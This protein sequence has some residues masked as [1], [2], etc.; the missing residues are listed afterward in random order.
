MIK[1]INRKKEKVAKKA[2]KGNRDI[3]TLLRRVQKRQK[4]S[5]IKI[6]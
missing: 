2:P 5:F 1:T 6:G 3:R 4:T